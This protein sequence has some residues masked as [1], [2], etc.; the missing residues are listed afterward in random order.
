MNRLRI[1]REKVAKNRERLVQVATDQFR[2]H[3][4]DAVGV[5]DLMKEV[6]MSL[7]SFYGYFDSKEHLVSECCTR[8][9]AET[10]DRITAALLW[11]ARCFVPVRS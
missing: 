9:I 2:E 8:V 5:A 4:I 7:G 11:I 10:K 6:G 3:G 1:S